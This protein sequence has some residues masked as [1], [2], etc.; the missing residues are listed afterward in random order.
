MGT[1]E[2][3]ATELGEGLKLT[4]LGRD[5]KFFEERLADD[6]MLVSQDGQTTASDDMAKL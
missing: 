3:E 1:A 2:S 6:V 5:P 4:E